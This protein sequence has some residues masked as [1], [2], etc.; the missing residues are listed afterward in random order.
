MENIDEKK[1]KQKK[2]HFKLDE[3]NKE[4]QNEKFMKKS[5]SKPNQS[6]LKSGQK[7][8]LSKK[9]R[10]EDPD[11]PLSAYFL[12]CSEKRKKSKDKKLTALELSQIYK[13]L[14]DN[15]K[16]V[17][18]E[19]YEN[20]LK[21]YYLVK[22]ILNLDDDNENTKKRNNKKKVLI[23]K[24]DQRNIIFNEIALIKFGLTF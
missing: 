2:V 21:A 16:Q 17:Y 12:F 9:A 6:K 1:P 4:M 5:L 13:A 20:D 10:R 11:K 18:I 22:D 15:E 23:S 19:K 7:N 3:K 8:L 24:K 14:D